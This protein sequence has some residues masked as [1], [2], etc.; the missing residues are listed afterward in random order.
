M[1]KEQAEQ[2]KEILWSYEGDV[3]TEAIIV[4]ILLLL[5]K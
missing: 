3:I 4:Q 1:S 2:L 5:D